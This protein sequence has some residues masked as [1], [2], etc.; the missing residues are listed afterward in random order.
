MSSERETVDIENTIDRNIDKNDKNIDKSDKTD[1]PNKNIKAIRKN[2][3]P[4]LPKMLNLRII[5]KKLLYVIGL[6]S[7]LAFKDVSIIYIISF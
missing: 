7:N 3:F 1:F 5:Q 6:S 2:F 4:N